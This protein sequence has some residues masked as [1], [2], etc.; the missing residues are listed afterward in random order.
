MNKNIL[1]LT[2]TIGLITTLFIASCTKD[3]GKLPVTA[4][5]PSACD[6][7]TYTKHIKPIIE[8]TCI[9][10]HGTPPNP[11]AP[12]LTTY[13]EVKNNSSK[14]RKTVLDANPAP[15][16]MPQGGPPLPQAQKDLISCWLDNG[17]KE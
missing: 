8:N 3:E 11:G 9:S 7:I 10:C 12:L 15:E 13:T 6:T 14:I 2:L 1:S 4:A 5:A 16:L 17:M